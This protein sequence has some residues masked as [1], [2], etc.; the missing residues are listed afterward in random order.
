[1]NIRPVGVELFHAERQL[2]GGNRHAVMTEV[3]ANFA[4]SPKKIS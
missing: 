1:M 2:G 3:F 4:K